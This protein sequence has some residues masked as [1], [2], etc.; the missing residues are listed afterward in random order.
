MKKAIACSCS[1]KG[2]EDALIE[3]GQSQL[4]SRRVV[5][6][7]PCFWA[8]QHGR[9][10]LHFRHHAGQPIGRWHREDRH[11]RAGSTGA[12]GSAA[13]GAK[14]ECC[15][16]GHSHAGQRAP[17]IVWASKLFHVFTTTGHD[18]HPTGVSALLWLWHICRRSGTSDAAHG[19]ALRC[20]SSAYDGNGRGRHTS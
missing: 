16:S 7:R 13:A 19:C 15:P 12:S 4:V 9:A 1:A 6:A 20:C 8:R 2:L 18:D 5:T 14:G 10:A 3:F 11:A 17:S